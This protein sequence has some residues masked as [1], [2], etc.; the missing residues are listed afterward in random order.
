MIEE[1]R[2]WSSSSSSSSSSTS[3]N[4]Q[5]SGPRY[6]SLPPPTSSTFNSSTSGLQFPSSTLDRVPTPDSEVSEFYSPT[7]PEYHVS[8]P[9]YSPTSP[10]YSPIQRMNYDNDSDPPNGN[11]DSH[12][13]MMITSDTTHP[14]VYPVST[15]VDYPLSICQLLIQQC[16]DDL[17]LAR[18]HNCLHDINHYTI[19]H[20]D[21]CLI[22]SI[23]S[24]YPSS[25]QSS[26]RP[27]SISHHTDQYRTRFDWL[28]VTVCDSLVSEAEQAVNE[29]MFSGN[30]ESPWYSLLEF[31]KVLQQAL[32]DRLPTGSLSSNTSNTNPRLTAP[33]TKS[34]DTPT[35]FMI[36]HN[37]TT[38][39]N[40]SSTLTSAIDCATNFLDISRLRLAHM[41]TH[42]HS[43]QAIGVT[44]DLIVD[45]RHIHDFLL[46][47]P[48]SSP[49]SSITRRHRTQIEDSIL[50]LADEAADISSAELRYAQ[51]SQDDAHIMEAQRDDYMCWYIYLELVQRLP[52]FPP[53]PSLTH[54]SPVVSTNIEQL[55]PPSLENPIFPDT[56]SLVFNTPAEVSPT[57]LNLQRSFHPFFHKIRL[58]LIFKTPLAPKK[59][60][61]PAFHK[62]LFFRQQI[63]HLVGYQDVLNHFLIFQIVW[64]I[65][66]KI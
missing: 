39:E 44:E 40:N 18:T 22:Q 49:S 8:T 20:E 52:A 10:P 9:P 12:I 14:D 25:P 38:S 30:T 4:S 32:H 60:L 23:L 57:L 46:T 16:L 51:H 34:M 54:P 41:I 6:P 47:L 63:S 65:L 1:N 59:S 33:R 56:S 7:P 26:C 5:L 61:F 13:I 42:N 28:A 3:S 11:D 48:V 31:Y 45:L 27:V 58:S 37:D 15:K 50:L 21:L 35:V 19:L 36:E 66:P 2:W 24:R 55:N 53:L 64:M 43:T 29:D 62:I 17:Q